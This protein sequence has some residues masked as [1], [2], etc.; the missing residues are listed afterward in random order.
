MGEMFGMKDHATVIHGCKVISNL[1]DTD[2]KFRQKYLI[3]K[4]EAGRTRPGRLPNMEMSLLDQL[5]EVLKYNSAVNMKIGLRNV[6]AT[7]KP[8]IQ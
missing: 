2:K 8:V 7:L 3:L 6:I 1:C 4:I 5:Q